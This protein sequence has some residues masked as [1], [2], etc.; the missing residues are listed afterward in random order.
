MHESGTRHSR[1]QARRHAGTVA[2]RWSEYVGG[3]AP[4]VARVP[5]RS[6][7]SA[8]VWTQWQCSVLVRVETG[9][10]FRYLP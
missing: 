9:E 3:R 2:S 1:H 10:A 5:V 8:S 6:V 4:A 7:A